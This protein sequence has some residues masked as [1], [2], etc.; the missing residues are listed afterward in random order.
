MSM[1]GQSGD[2][3]FDYRLTEEPV[4]EKDHL[5][6]SLFGQVTSLDEYKSTIAQPGTYKFN[7]R[8]EEALQFIVTDRVVNT[9]LQTATEQGVFTFDS[10]EAPYFELFN[11]TMKNLTTDDF[12][13]YPELAQTYGE[14]K[15]VYEVVEVF[16]PKV[17]F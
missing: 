10:R 16:F 1:L 14:G 4:V 2:Y 17:K 13:E 5:Q 15:P 12:P 11:K 7:T 3:A 8:N 9:L 6:L